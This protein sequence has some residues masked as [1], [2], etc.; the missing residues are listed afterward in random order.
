MIFVLAGFVDELELLSQAVLPYPPIQ[1]LEPAIL[2]D[3]QLELCATN[4]GASA[5]PS[6][7]QEGSKATAS[8]P[9]LCHGSIFL[10]DASADHQPPPSIISLFH[11]LDGGIPIRRWLVACHARSD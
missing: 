2:G 9:Q 11:H 1:A 8:T 10:Q 5:V 7:P 3:G 6:A 4:P